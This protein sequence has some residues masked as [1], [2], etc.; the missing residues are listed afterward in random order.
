MQVLC[1]TLYSPYAFAC[2]K[3]PPKTHIMLF[4]KA[5]MLCQHLAPASSA[6]LFH[7]F[8]LAAQ[9]HSLQT[10]KPRDLE[11]NIVYYIIACLAPLERHSP[12]RSSI[13]SDR[14]PILVR[15]LESRCVVQLS[16]LNKGSRCYFLNQ[17]PEP[18]SPRTPEREM[19]SHINATPPEPQR[20]D[21]K[22]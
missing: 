15:P 4:I 9:R 6:R 3:N 5:V 22:P 1:R 8:K 2:S 7:V 11:P 10:S 19:P 14:K 20:R 17:Q 12:R 16:Q 21:P 18:C 13:L